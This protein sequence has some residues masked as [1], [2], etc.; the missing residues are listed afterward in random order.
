MKAPDLTP[1][2]AWK[3]YSGK[4]EFTAGD[5]ASFAGSKT[6]QFSAVPGKGG[7]QVVSLVFSYF[8]PA[9]EA[10]KTITSPSEKIQV[11]GKD[12]VDIGPISSPDANEPEKK[13][14]SLVGQHLEMSP[15]ASL[16]PLVSRPD[17]K[18]MLVVSAVFG[19]LGILFAL[20]T[21]RREDP[22]RV[23]LA[24]MEKATREALEAAGKCAAAKDVTGWFA[25]ARLAIQQQLGALWNQPAQA[26]TLAEITARISDDSPVARFFREADRYEYSRQSTG[27]ILPQWRSLL[28][29]AMS[30]LTPYAH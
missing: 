10:Y 17:F 19:L 30:S 5:V 13:V 20:L 15:A 29:E 22:E 2:E 4:D 11:S 8:D 25:S 7:E 6:F 3:T 28:D 18:I 21:K 9:A 12:I 24:A 26:I 27:D 1:A 16:V 23:A 14:A